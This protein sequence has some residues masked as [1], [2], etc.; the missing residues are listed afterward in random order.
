M[1]QSSLCG[2]LYS[3]LKVIKIRF[4]V[5]YSLGSGGWPTREALL[6]WFDNGKRLGTTL[7]NRS[8]SD[9]LK[10]LYSG[11]DSGGGVY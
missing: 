9:I 1:G 4:E 6:L 2:Y 5:A 3:R 7:A 10:L 11:T 8:A